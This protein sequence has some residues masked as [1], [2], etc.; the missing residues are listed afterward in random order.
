MSLRLPLWG[1][2]FA[3]I[4]SVYAPLM[5]SFNAA[6][7]KFYEDLYA[8]LASVSKADKTD[9]VAWRVVLDPYGLDGSNVN[10]LLVLSTCAV[11]RLILTNTLFR[12]PLRE[13]ATWMH[14]WSRHR[15][16]LN[17]I[18]V[19]RRDQR[20]VLVT[21]VLPGAT[22]GPTIVSSSP[23]CE[24]AYSLAGDLK[25][26]LPPTKTPLW[27]TDGVNWGTH[28]G[29]VLGHA[30]HQH[31]DWLDDSNAAINNLL[32][33]KNRLHKAYVNRPTDHNKAALYRSRRLVQ[34]RLQEMEDAWTAHKAEEIQGYAD[35]NEWKNTFAE[36][37]AV[38]GP[39][40]KATSLFLSADSRSLLT[41]ETQPLQ[42][43]AEHFR[44]VLN[45]PSIISDAAIAR[46]PQVETKAVLDVP[47]F[48]REAI[49]TVR[50]PSSG[51]APGSDQIP[52]GIYK[53]SSPHPVNHL[54]AL[55]QMW[56]QDEIPQH[57]K[58]ATIVHLY[59]VKGNRQI[60]GNHRGISLLNIAGK[61]SDCIILNC[62][63]HHMEQG[64][65]L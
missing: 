65:L 43:W 41:A 4:V 18:L 37:K 16:L 54:T 55:Y 51:K 24:F 11:H 46:L 47:P 3:T 39:P 53:H 42:R 63:D 13:K 19:Q 5:T 7:N 31:G 56:R 28:C 60:C 50:Q 45:L 49:S 29:T 17:H 30:R 38:Y 52:D 58:D 48:P 20:D 36:I 1:G 64:Y 40:T 12:L 25:S 2:K 6:K 44:G 21:N 34:Q 15:Q 22:G 23:R 61:I 27:K 8:L 32:A 10:G 26:P 62:L 57:S 14:P 33:E 9:H 35:R 59:K